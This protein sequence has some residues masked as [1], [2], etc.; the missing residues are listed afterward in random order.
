[1][2]N[3][4]C[5]KCQDSGGDSA[6][7]NLAIY[8]DGKFCFACGYVEKDNTYSGT[9]KQTP[10]PTA[11]ISSSID[12]IPDRAISKQTCEF[13]GYGQTAY[14]GCIGGRDVINESVHVATYKTSLGLPVSQ[15][16]RTM[17]KEMKLLGSAK[18]TPLYGQWLWEP[19]PNKFVT[20]VEGEIDA[21]SVVEV[22]GK[23]FACVSV[24]FGAGSAKSSLKANLEWLQ[25]FKYVVLALDNDESGHTATKECISLFEPGKVRVATWQLK[26]ANE[27]LVEGK[28]QNITQILQDARLVRPDGIVTYSDVV[29]QV[30][31]KPTIGINW[32]WPTL[33]RLTYGLRDHELITIM[34]ASGIGK[35]EWVAEVFI[36]LIQNYGIK[37]GVMSFEQPAHKTFQRAIGKL[38]NKR[39]HVPG[40]EFDVDEVNRLGEEVFNEKLFCY[41]R[42]GTVKWEDVRSK[43]IYYVKGLDCKVIVIDNLSSIAAKFDTDERRGIDRAML[44][45]SELAMTLGITI[46]LVCHVSRL[47]PNAV[48]YEAGGRVTLRNARG[49][50]GIGQHS[51]Y[52]FGL[53]RNTLAENESE[54]NITTI[55]CLKDREYGTARGQSFC[56]QYNNETGRLEELGL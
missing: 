56:I 40:V 12:S 54:R 9:P 51:T 47:P 17:T 7:D 3:E 37:C 20:V 45:L 1:M 32:P 27:M 33:T 39:I 15:K 19:N 25:G 21:L 11:L 55:R 6:G 30:L 41:S 34:A 14:T 8:D 4:A 52:V 24:P 5:P 35:T 31:T 16:L 13:F 22:Q 46:I 10:T 38:L 50:E 23:Q 49:S 29:Q 43:L 2:R 18:E 53:E 36:H 26:D 48:P 44:E 42:A 28:A